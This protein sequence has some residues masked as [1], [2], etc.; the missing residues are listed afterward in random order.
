MKR[1]IRGVFISY[2]RADAAGSA[3][4][5]YDRL[6]G[7]LGTDRVFMDVAGIESGEDFAEIIDATLASCSVF[8]VVIGRNWLTAADEYGRRRVDQPADWVRVE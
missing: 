4:R 8:I 5:L 1:A 6:V 3:G 7:A 2:R